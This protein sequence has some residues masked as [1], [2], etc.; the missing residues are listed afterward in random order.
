M[1]TLACSLDKKLEYAL[2]GSIFVGGAVVQWLRDDLRIIRTSA[3]VEA[4]AASVPDTDGVVLVPAFTGLGAPHWDPYARGLLIGIN[5]DTSRDTLRGRRSKASRFQVADV[6]EAWMRFG[7][8]IQGIAGGWR[9]GGEQ[10]AD[11]VPGGSAADSGG[12][13]GGVETT[14]LGAAYLAGLATG[15]WGSPQE[16]WGK[17]KGDVRF[18]PKMDEAKARQFASAGRRRLGGRSIGRNT[19][20]TRGIGTRE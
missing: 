11:A 7:E 20:V 14:A 15:F 16:I 12:A 6:L 3:E 13:A 10:F 5:R 4:L 2:E 8:A 1:T 19:L 18:S 17:R 9:R